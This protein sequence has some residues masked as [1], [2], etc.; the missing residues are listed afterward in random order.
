MIF[1]VLY[2]DLRMTYFASLKLFK[3]AVEFVLLLMAVLCGLSRVSDYKHHWSDVFAGLAIGT[4]LSFFFVFR[5]LQ[6]HRVS[7]TIHETPSND[8]HI[9]DSNDVERGESP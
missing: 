5:V 8:I 3:P 9:Q 1:L 6:L 7:T 2:V 4:F